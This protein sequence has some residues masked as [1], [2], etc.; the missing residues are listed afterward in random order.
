MLNFLKNFFT[1]D[2][3]LVKSGG[4]TSQFLDWAGIKWLGDG[5]IG[6]SAEGYNKNVVAYHCINSIATAVAS[7]PYTVEINGKEVENDKINQLLRRPNSFQSYKEFMHMLI[8]H[9]MIGGNCYIY[10]TTVYTGRIMSMQIFRPDR[11]SIMSDIYWRPYK[12]IYALG[13]I[14]EIP[15]DP[16]TGYSDLL[17]IKNTNPINDLYGLSP[18]AVAAMSVSQHN[19]SVTW[20]QKLIQNSAKPSGIITM[21]DKGENGPGLTQ[22]QM[23]DI[24][25]KFNN[26]YQGPENAGKPIIF[27]YDMLW[28]PMGMTPADMDWLNGKN[29]TARDICLAFNYPPQLLGQ[30]EGSTFNNMGVARQSFYEDTIIPLCENMLEEIAWWISYHQKQ[31]IKIIPNVDNLPALAA[32]RETMRASNRSDVAGGILKINEARE[33]MGYESVPGGDQL[34]VPANVL[35]LDFALEPPE[36]SNPDD[37]KDNADP[38][39]PMDDTDP[40]DT[41]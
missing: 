39:D 3:G 12:Y 13:N 6:F 10:G 27:S 8:L 35:P 40:K 38:K 30:E 5:Y 16:L 4:F 14:R 41:E 21:K 11:I 24:A 1:L 20:N 23:D 31:D 28:Q 37:P 7:I 34:L 32:R 25:Y 26:K 9:R 36:V 19:E 2:A 29:S 18:M 33:A 15:V 22:Q 17:H